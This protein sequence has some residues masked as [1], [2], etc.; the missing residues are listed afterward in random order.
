[1]PVNRT[2]FILFLF[3]LFACA[4]PQ[5]YVASM[6]ALEKH[7]PKRETISARKGCDV[8]HKIFAER[9]VYKY[10]PVRISHKSHSR[11][12]I[13][14]NFCHRG[15]KSSMKTNDYLTPAGH[16]FTDKTS[17]N[18][19]DR[20]PCRICHIYSSPFMK[21]E[22]R[23]AICRSC[24]S[25]YSTDKPLPYRWVKFNTNLINNH[26]AHYD[27]GV[28]CLRCHVGFDLLEEP[29]QN[30]IPKMDICY[31]CHADVERK[32][33]VRP[34]DQVEP[35]EAAGR[36]YILNCS[37]CHG[38]DGKGGGAM[39]A[40]FRAGL[41]P[42]DLTDSAHFA[43]RSDQQLRDVILKGG[44][45][46]GLSERMPAWEGL[47]SEEEVQSLVTYIRRISRKPE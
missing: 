33:D 31:E 5:P 12:G 16:G 25:S 24:H 43:K 29:V 19:S 10:Y 38:A 9:L 15:A 4:K 23:S 40:F 14:C 8:C 44:V 13:E 2:I 1:M 45:E 35:L 28:P 22:K 32:A 37:M 34:T 26:K 11:L 18:A 7:Q 20:N 3:F 39:A 42:R 46:I 30:Y 36:I 17:E 47:L 21:K 27:R 41:T 6:A